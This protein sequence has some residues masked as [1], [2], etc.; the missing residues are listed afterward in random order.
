MLSLYSIISSGLC[1]C[2]SACERSF[3]KAFSGGGRAI[4]YTVIGIRILAFP[5]ISTGV[6]GYPVEEAA[7]VAVSTAKRFVK[8]HPDAFDRILWVLLDDRTH[9]VYEAEVK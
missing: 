4:C 3:G 8:N 1:L 2:S 6:L 5:S 7:E 9:S